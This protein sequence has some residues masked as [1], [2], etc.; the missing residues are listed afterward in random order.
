M[1]FRKL[2]ILLCVLLLPSATRAQETPNSRQARQMFDQAYRKV[3]GP[4]GATLHYAVNLIG[5]YKTEGT[6]WYKGAKSSFVES[7]YSSWCDG[8]TFYRADKKKQTVEI[9][10]P[11][12]DKKDQYMNKFKF[13]PDNYTYHIAAV[14]EGLEITLHAKSGVKG[15]KH[16]K[17]VLDRRTRD[18]LSLKVK[19]AFFWTTVKISNFRSGNIDDSIFIFPR[20]RFAGYRF[21]DK[22]PD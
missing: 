11:N 14:A 8:R 12:S 10:N 15:I 7:R 5:I 13:D 16:V 1:Q 21:I 9:H 18:P 6:I 3:F 20:T 17:A 4:Q 19:L 2:L 22:R